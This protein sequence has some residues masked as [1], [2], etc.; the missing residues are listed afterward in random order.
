MF[1]ESYEQKTTGGGKF[2]SF[3]RNRVNR[4]VLACFVEDLRRGVS[5]LGLCMWVLHGKN[6]QM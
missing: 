5:P 1:Y 4:V 6:L 3:I 2:T